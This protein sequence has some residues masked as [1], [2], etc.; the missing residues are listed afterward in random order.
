MSS[1]AMVNVFAAGLLTWVALA[2][3]SPAVEAMRGPRVH[4]SEAGESSNPPALSSPK[5]LHVQSGVAL[6]V[7]LNRSLS[8]AQS[9]PG[10]R[11]TATLVEPVQVDGRTVFHKG[12]QVTGLVE[13]S[14]PAGRFKGQAHL[15]LSLES[16][17]VD[18]RALALST[19]IK[20]RNGRRHRKHNAL[21]IGGGSGTGALIGG[22][23][24]GPVGMVVGA[25]SGAAAGLAGA[26]ITS[27][28]Q[29]SLPA[30]TLLTFR[31]RA[32]VDL[33]ASDEPLPRQALNN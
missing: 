20:T 23:A 27:R 1:H 6:Q 33:P 5:G 19:S 18:G 9:R 8:T 31:L 17:Q 13:E 3:Q 12:A 15:M 24:G 11:F 32:P 30:E 22:L 10:D 26:L 2:T 29:I 28:K 7:R 16:I 25:G 21:W 4:T 14:A